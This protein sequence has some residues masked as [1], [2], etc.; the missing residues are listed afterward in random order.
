MRI[1][2][3]FEGPYRFLS[4]FHPATIS[5]NVGFGLVVYPDVEHAYQCSK[6]TN[7]EDH[8]WILS[9]LTPA[10]AKK[11]GSKR[12]IKVGNRYRRIKLRNDW[13]EVKL[14]IML[15]LLRLKFAIPDLRRRLLATGNSMLI[16]GNWWGDTFW[17]V[18]D[19]VGGNHLGR[20]IMQVRR[21][22]RDASQTRS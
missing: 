17:G 16:E 18:Y 20:L 12:G 13:E 9:R 6:T 2:E 22:I 15:D 14:A 4:D 8:N 5:C 10:L 11:A 21:E 1:I 19:G 3:E 7:L